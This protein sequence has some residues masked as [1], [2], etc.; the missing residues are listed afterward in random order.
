[1]AA[2]SHKQNS[3]CGDG[4]NLSSAHPVRGEKLWIIFL[5]L[6]LVIMAAGGGLFWLLAGDLKHQQN[7]ELAA[8]AEL[9]ARQVEDWLRNHRLFVRNRVEGTILADLVALWLRDQDPRRADLVRTQLLS[10]LRMTEYVSA[11]FFDMEG[12]RLLAIGDADMETPDVR[13]LIAESLGLQSP[14]LS[15][16]HPR[17]ASD[18][19][20]RL[21]FLTLVRDPNDPRHPPLGAVLYGVDPQWTLFPLVR[22]WPRASDSGETMMVR[23]VGDEVEYLTELRHRKESSSNFRLPLSQENLVAAKAVL[24]G[25][26]VHE[27]RDYRGV[28]VLS[29]SEPVAGAPW[30]LVAKIDSKE[31]YAGIGRLSL[32]T[33]IIA[34]L[35][36]LATGLMVAMIW[37]HQRLREALVRTA[38]ARTI[39]RLEHRFRITLNSIGEAII[40]TSPDGLIEFLNPEAEVLTGW[41]EADALGRVLDEVFVIFNEETHQA[42]ESP[43][44][45]VLNEKRVVDQGNHI[46]LV[47]RDGIQRP[48][49]DSGAPIFDD[50]GEI[51]GVVLV[52]RDQTKERAFLSELHES[53]TRYRT[54]LDNIP[55]MVWEKDRDSVY[56]SGNASCARVLGVDPSALV[57]KVDEDFFPADLAAQHRE[58]DCRV[59]EQGAIQTKE[60]RW[61]R[62][63]QD[64]VIRV[65]KVALRD[66]LG[67]VYGTLGISED[68]TERKKAEDQL[69]LAAQVFERAGEGIMVTDA[70]QRVLTV[71]AAFTVITGC[72]AEEICGQTPRTLKSGLHEPSYYQ[73]MWASIAERGW[74]QGEI[75]NRRKS[76]E[77]YLGW[78]TINS[79]RNESGVVTNYVGMFSDITAVKETQRRVDYLATHDELTGLPNRTLF[80]DRLRQTIVRASRKASYFALMFVDLDNFKVV[81][82]SLGHA[83]GDALLIEVSK[84]LRR[85]VRA[86]DSVARFGGDEFALLIDDTNAS[87]VEVAASRVAATLGELVLIAGKGIH[88]S[89]SIGICFFPDDGSDPETLLKNAD[90]AMY[91]AKEEGKSTFRFFTQQL[92][93]AVDERLHL[94]AG[95]RRAIDNN[96]L[97]LHYQPQ[98]ELETG[99]VVGVE[100]LVRWLHP[101]EGMI[102]PDRFIPVAEKSGLIVGLGEWVANA[103]C[104]QMV[105]WMSQGVDPRRV[106]I[107]VSGEQFKRAQPLVMLKKLLSHHGLSPDKLVVE[108]TESAVMGDVD[109]VQRV[110]YDLKDLGLGISIDD[111]GTG[112]SSLSYLRR[113]P[114]DEIKIDR[115]FVDDIARSP[116]DR[117]IAQTII[118]MSKTLGLSVVAEGVETQEQFGILRDLGCHIGQGY[119][120]AKP[121][122]ASDLALFCREKEMSGVTS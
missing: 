84:R 85:C 39:D 16:L 67:Q 100:A 19:K 20:D 102:R 41:R 56:V 64:Q 99:R 75:W 82:D 119:L 93:S 113:F 69:R 57:G 105:L 37:R 90:S 114:I 4:A 86:M 101:D 40:A 15:D 110:L 65:T 74:W 118:A 97:L 80:L 88:V 31:V 34:L 89:A 116:D 44:T 45:R 42:V 26:G 58:G 109:Q 96:E 92:K 122:P 7:D 29:A 11:E 27:G 61:N 1:M 63:G 121:M 66:D 6:A 9:K 33:V 25:R 108:L 78:L 22:A 79:V 81:N 3:E 51:I 48:I 70:E 98:I 83:A 28:D 10:D 107:N 73:E 47:G 71:N 111:F 46:T 117:A 50:A 60:E 62:D 95:L 24:Q 32:N 17:G 43:V 38:Q 8:V 68:V 52:F 59:M 23:R 36:I 103:A 21:G 49:A 91:H 53:V 35:A 12:R 77:L 30:V 120:F 112:F 115:S 104:E 72:S 106:S 54:L 87:E 2:S 13:S 76:G 5:A 18:G 55:Q 94:E 14:V